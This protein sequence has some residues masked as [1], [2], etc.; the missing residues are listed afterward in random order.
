[1]QGTGMVGVPG[2]ASTIF[3][4]MRDA[5]VNVSMISQASSEHSVCFAVRQS[6]GP[7]AITAL[8][9]RSVSAGAPPVQALHVTPPSQS[10]HHV[11]K[12]NVYEARPVRCYIFVNS[13]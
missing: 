11:V 6:D 5:D 4:T 13:C 10:A 1:M 7:R 2:T 8:Q 12:T 3:S 9:S